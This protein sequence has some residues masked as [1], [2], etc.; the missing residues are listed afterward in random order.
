[1]SRKSIK[2]LLTEMKDLSVLAIDL[3]YGGI[4]FHST[5]IAE[6]VLTIDEKMDELR[7]DLEKA[8]F[9]TCGI[10]GEGTDLIGVIRMGSYAER[11]AGVA[12]EMARKVISGKIH[13]IEKHALKEAEE[14]IIRR[15]IGS[16][17]NKKTVSDY[18]AEN[19][20]YVFAIKRK[21]EWIYHPGG[22][23]QLKTNDVVFGTKP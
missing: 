19:T 4:L 17:F 18:G 7:D 15:K 22:R 9:N 13:E 14:K 21:K 6:E 5:E 10:G 12:A 20:V 3:A 2:E 1:M 11:I 23:V 16:D 8:V